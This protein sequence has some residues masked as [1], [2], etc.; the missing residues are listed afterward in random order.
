MNTRVKPTSLVAMIFI[1]T[2]SVTG[3]CTPTAFAQAN[4]KGRASNEES[5]RTELHATE[6]MVHIARARAALHRKDLVDARTEIQAAST[7]IES[8]AENMPTYMLHR[9]IEIAKLHLSYGSPGDAIRDL[10]PIRRS[11]EALTD[12]LPVHVTDQYYAHIDQIQGNME[13]SERESALNRLMELDDAVEYTEVDMP[14]HSTR[15]HISD[16]LTAINL[17]NFEAADNALAAA[18]D[19][20]Q[21]ISTDTV[22]LPAYS[23]RDS[24]RRAEKLYEQGW[25]E[26]AHAEVK[27]A[28]KLLSSM[29][30]TGTEK[31][32]K[33]AKDLSSNAESLLEDIESK[34]PGT[35]NRIRHLVTFAHAFAERDFKL[36][37]LDPI[38]ANLIEA[39]FHVTRAAADVELGRAVDEMQKAHV[40]AE[41]E[42][43][44]A[45]RY[46]ETANA[47]SHPGGQPALMEV[48]DEVRQLATSPTAEPSMEKYY[49]IERQIRA[50]IRRSA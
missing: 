38:A 10:V 15:R 7:L 4:I 28:I 47:R 45:Q 24:L 44:R 21:V 49:S 19:S 32:R 5:T 1:S 20:F 25:F 9:R 11:V 39:E 35:E 18:E 13:R 26:K 8:V 34:V 41:E 17:N 36:R 42:L 23:V 48:L 40:T 31:T 46:L 43:K 2:L 22:A 6:V 30:A 50:L 16:A 37:H 3:F 14:V 27:H 12:L 33:Y 29:A